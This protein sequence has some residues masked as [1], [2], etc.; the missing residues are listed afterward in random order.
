M[1]NAVSQFTLMG[2]FHPFCDHLASRSAHESRCLAPGAVCSFSSV[3]HGSFSIN[4]C[5]SYFFA[6][7]QPFFEN[8][9]ARS[10]G[11]FMLMRRNRIPG[12]E[13]PAFLLIQLIAFMQK[14]PREP[15]R[16]LSRLFYDPSC[17]A[18]PVPFSRSQSEVWSVTHRGSLCPEA[19]EQEYMTNLRQ[20]ELHQAQCSA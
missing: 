8:K 13:R 17:S 19:A 10:T 3:L 14:A 15:A 1:E 18:P 12:E 7:L 5:R 4:L 6:V 9:G 11:G 16:F 2:C 20:T